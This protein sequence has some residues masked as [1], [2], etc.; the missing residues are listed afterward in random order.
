MFRIIEKLRVGE[1]AYLL[2]IQASQVKRSK[3]GQFVIVQRDELSERIPLSI[4]ESHEYGF[5]C[6]L[7]VVGRSTMELL[8]EGEELLYIA[9]PLGVPFPVGRYGRVLFYSHDWGIAPILNVAR[10]LKIEGNFLKLVHTSEELYLMDQVE[11]VFHLWDV[12]SDPLP[13]ECD[14]V[15]SA[16][17]NHLSEKLTQ[18]YPNK[19]I[20]S[21]VNVHMLDAVGLCLVC[22]VRVDG[23]YRLACSEGPWFE[24]H[25]VDWR[26]LISRENIYKEQER[27]ATEEYLKLLKRR[28]LKG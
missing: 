21:M 24:A 14:L 28:E 15:V 18:L 10:A 1:K 26:D 25:K 27:Q 13:E 8:E 17:S 22:R 20:L 3:P 12:S 19:P 16:G 7:K 23:E 5:S 9:G 6:L 11:R 4:L 2:K